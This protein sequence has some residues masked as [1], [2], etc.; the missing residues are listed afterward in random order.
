MYRIE[1]GPYFYWGKTAQ[2]LTKRRSQHLSRLRKG[3][4]VSRFMTNVFNKHGEGAFSLAEHFSHE[5]PELIDLV[6]EELILR[7]RGKPRCMNWA[8]GGNPGAYLKGR[9]QSPEHVARRVEAMRGYTH[10]PEARAKMA[11]AWTPDR[12]K[13]QSIPVA[14]SQD[15]TTWES[16]DSIKAAARHIGGDGG[17]L[18]RALRSGGICKGWQVRR[19]EVEDPTV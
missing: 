19:K 11:E 9:K 16:F 4:G 18:S 7:D 2:P 12:Q 8:V 3:K 1:I 5:D 14:V 17:N 13:R 15:G 6:E 10:G